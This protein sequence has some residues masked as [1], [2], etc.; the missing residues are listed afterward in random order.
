MYVELHLDKKVAKQLSSTFFQKEEANQVLK[1]LLS[2]AQASNRVIPFTFSLYNDEKKQSTFWSLS[3]DSYEIGGRNIIDNFDWYFEE[4]VKKFSDEKDEISKLLAYY[5]G[6]KSTETNDEPDVVSLFDN[7]KKTFSFFS[8]FKKTEEET[9]S[10]EFPDEIVTDIQEESHV[11]ELPDIVEPNKLS[12]PVLEKSEKNIKGKFFFVST[13]AVVFV[14]VSIFCVLTF[15]PKAP[16]V[17]KAQIVSAPKVQQV[18]NDKLIQSVVDKQEKGTTIEV[19]Q[20]NKVVLVITK[21]EKGNTKIT[22]KD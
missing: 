14:A 12:E 4:D 15:V 6:A 16:K 19:E 1:E 22:Y 9:D 5:Y 17:S 8:R 21:D 20:K 7:K 13:M 18:K 2:I 11:T 3:A 10:T